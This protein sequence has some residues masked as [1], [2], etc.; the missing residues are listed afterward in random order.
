VARRAGTLS[1]AKAKE[2]IYSRTLILG[3]GESALAER[4]S[5]FST[6]KPN[7]LPS[8]RSEA[9]NSALAESQAE[10]QQ[11]ISP[12]EQKLKKLRG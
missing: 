12:V 3:I 2:I 1:K 11:L 5:T 7:G 8:W 10:A 4:W 6:P 9:A